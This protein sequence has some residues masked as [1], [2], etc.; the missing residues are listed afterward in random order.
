MY[1]EE[2]S[3]SNENF[4][5]YKERITNFSSEFEF[6]LFMYIAKKSIVWIILLLILAVSL[7]FLYLRYTPPIYQSSLTLQIGN[8]NT[9]D[10]ILN[11][12]D[13]Y[14]QQD[15][16][17]ELEILRSKFLLHRAIQTLPL[18]ISYFN[19]GQ[20]LTHEL[21]V[22]CPFR[23]EH[24]VLDS[25]IINVPIYIRF[26]DRE[27]ATI[28]YESG[29]QHYSQTFNINENVHLDKLICKI[30]VINYQAIKETQSQVK[31]QEY[32][33]RINDLEA[34]TDE[35]IDRVDA[36]LLSN[37]AKTISISFRD[38]NPQKTVDIT[39]ALA[40]QFD[41]YDE[42]TKSKS[43]TKV[44]EFINM[45]LDIVYRRLKASESSITT[46]KKNNKLPTVDN[47]SDLYLEKLNTLQ[48]VLLDLNLQIDVLTEIEQSVS[49]GNT[50]TDAYNLL[51]ILIGTEYESSISDMVLNL[52]DLLIKKE[53]SQFEVTS[54]SKV[55]NSLDHQIAIQK[56]LIRES[57]VGLKNKL[58]T[59]RR[60]INQ[61]VEEIE[62]KFFNI[63]EK[64]IEYARLQR[65]F[66]AD[67]KFFTLLLEKRTEY[68]ISKAGFV[69]QNVIL[70]GAKL[71]TVPISPDK[72]IIIATFLLGGISLS[73]ILIT[74][75][76]LIHNN[77]ISLNEI[78]RHTH[79]SIGILGIVPKYKKDIPTSQLVVNKNPKSLIAE[80]FRTI[81]TNLQFIST[82]HGPKVM[83]ITSTVSGEGKTF[84]ALNL[85]GIIA[86]SGK[87][88]IILDLDMRKPKIHSGFGVENTKGM[89]TLL[90]QKDTIESCIYKSEQ[91]NLHFITAGPI[92]PNPSE[93]IINGIINDILETLKKNY[94]VIIIDTPPV[95]LVTDGI[96][97][98]QKA[99]YPIYIFR[100]EYSKKNFIQN[101]DR[102]FNENSLTRLS[103]ILNGVDITKNSYGYNYGYGYGYGYTYTSYGG[104]YEDH[105]K[106]TSFIKKLFK[107]A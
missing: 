23:I 31:Q 59:K 95:G 6:G 88:V 93:L 20:F 105:D 8:K 52:Q 101:V 67:E 45:Q 12:T 68:S 94:D 62:T 85:G 107:R 3:K 79:A 106:K 64:E 75:R 13:L 70:E 97:L 100:S 92:P 19:E 104:Y 66:S 80:S 17:A 74:L 15:I 82:V 90:I 32:F 47:F 86:F 22:N 69:P 91:E 7:S 16:F 84:I 42:E 96:N 11:A 40:R 71:P 61:K 1:N 54:D 55:I 30:D 18:E 46:F 98:I 5:R 103:I 53:K 83:A 48:D 35:Y 33:F 50:E 60:G 36:I 43:A 21:Y 44:L 28:W 65:L 14:D 2:I 10:K 41:E 34:L 81:R 102:M 78:T 29:N 51:P 63:P 49:G 24:T 89:S 77:I 57:V 72:K 39:T 87:K 56:K 9:A 38:N 27:N 99:D 26:K 73:L 37:A 76:Y 4:T 25:S 58:E